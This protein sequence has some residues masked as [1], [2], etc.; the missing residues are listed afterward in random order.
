MEYQR[1]F[2]YTAL[3]GL[4]LLLWMTWQQDYHRPPEVAQAPGV[5]QSRPLAQPVAPDVPAETEAVGEARLIRV[6]TDLMTAE[7][8]TVG[9]DVRSVRL[10]RYGIS[11]DDPTPIALLQSD[12]T[13]FYIAQS[14]LEAQD[15]AAPGVQAV[16]R[17][18]QDSYQLPEGADQLTV[19]LNWVDE[20]GIAVEKRYTF[21]RDSYVIDLEQRVHNHSV[22]PWQGF[23]Y[24]QLRRTKPEEKRSFMFG[25][26]SYTGGVVHGPDWRYKKISFDEMANRTLKGEPQRDLQGGWLAML[27]H[28]F[29]SAW[30]PP[31]DATYRY[32]ARAVDGQ[33][34]LGASSPWQLAQ[35]G[36][37]VVFT[38]KLYTGPKD[39]AR[40]AAVAPDLELTV[41]YGKLSIISKPLFWLLSKINALVG[42][43]GWAIV[44]LTLLIKVVFYKLSEAS[45]RSMARMRKVQPQMQALRERYGD[46]RQR[47]NQELMELYKRE[48]INPLGGCLPILIQIPVFIALYWVLLESVELR[49]ADWILWYRDLSSPDPYF[50]LPILM[51]ASMLLQQRLNPAPLD[52]IQQRVMTILPIV[53]TVFFVFFPAGLVLYWVTNNVLSIGQQWLITSRIE[54]SEKA[55]A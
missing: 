5:Q 4:L 35:P 41:D 28:Y 2:L 11:I 14:G 3:G 15:A 19:T 37:S 50:V 26:H 38:G 21:H 17:A 10:H 36:E 6:E 45:Y 30:V 48:K 47:L 9:G 44:L 1:L 27:Q 42:N 53:F 12:G 20:S 22:Q 52:P 24:V 13:R 34:I 55:K 8:S 32:Y 31:Q 25:A 23:Q 29:V 54:R 33:Y 46:D 16:F 7:I 18:E 43:W 51:G 39:Q 40:L 49:H